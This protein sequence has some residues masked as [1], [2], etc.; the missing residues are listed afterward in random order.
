MPG[1]GGWERGG[2][3]ERI[4]WRSDLMWKMS[5]GMTNGIQNA[6]KLRGKYLRVINI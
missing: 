4:A 1:A 2:F 6:V 5:L 3:T